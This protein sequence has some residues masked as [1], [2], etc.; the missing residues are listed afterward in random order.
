MAGRIKA[1]YNGI[2]QGLDPEACLSEKAQRTGAPWQGFLRY[3]T[4]L[5]RIGAK[6]HVRWSDRQER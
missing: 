5:P 2:S 3:G 6:L 4:S 1:G